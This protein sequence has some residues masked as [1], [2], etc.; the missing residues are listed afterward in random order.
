MI[1]VGTGGHSLDMLSDGY[2]SNNF[3]SLYFFNSIGTCSDKLLH[4]R[5]RVLTNYNEIKLLP[6]QDKR[7]ILAVGNPG[8]RKRLFELLISYDTSPFTYKS[9]TSLVS[10][11]ATIGFGSNLMPFSSV[12]GNPKI[13]KGVLIN[14]YSSIHHDSQIGDFCEISP[15]ARILGNVNLGDFVQIG[16]NATI[17]PGIKIGNSTIV[18]AGAVVTT[19]LPENCTAVGVPAKIVKS[20]GIR[21]GY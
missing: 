21:N 9:P 17:L 11:F 5:Y 8:I 19:D 7:F 12:L 1:I 15:G 16:S 10:V 4:N 2:L 18:G 13:G 3:N 20:L 14:S 6:L